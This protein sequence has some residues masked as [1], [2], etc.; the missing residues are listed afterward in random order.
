MK[1]ITIGVNYKCNLNCTF[2]VLDKNIKAAEISVDD[3]KKNIDYAAQ[4]GVETII[5]SGYGETLLYPDIIEV[6][7]YA[8]NKRVFKNISLYTNAL[9]L[10]EQMT[11]NLLN[12][13]ENDVTRFRLFISATGYDY[14]VY[15]SFQNPYY[16]D[17]TFRDKVYKNV[18]YFINQRNQNKVKIRAVIKY[19]LADENKHD[20]L[21]YC[22]F[23]EDKIDEIIITSLYPAFNQLQSF[24]SIVDKNYYNT[25]MTLCSFFKTGVDIAPNQDVLIC[26]NG[27]CAVA[28]P[29]VGNLKKQTLSEVL[30]SK[31]YK[32][33]YKALEEFDVENMP[34]CC[35]D[36][37]FLFFNEYNIVVTYSSLKQYLEGLLNNKKID[38][39][40][41]IAFFGAGVI[42]KRF[43]TALDVVYDKRLFDYVI[44][45]SFKEGRFANKDIQKPSK[46]ILDERKIIICSDT[47]FDDINNS[48]NKL[49]VEGILYSNYLSKSA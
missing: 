40:E 19:I 42:L 6:I 20:F 11:E 34:K 2:C 31:K 47:Y 17:V 26:C 43:L 23:W 18:Q 7:A 32:D 5:F 15:N 3:C 39:N 33:Y 13:E 36:C 48:L 41:K 22:R 8:V 27:A 28:K 44:I 14:N 24:K 30:N 12:I 46:V 38:K 37:E 4:A 29:I 10:D 1:A 45:D 16:K 21:D 35:L 9:A 49:G 25:K